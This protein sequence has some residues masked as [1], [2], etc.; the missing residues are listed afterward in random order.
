MVAHGTSQFIGGVISQ[1]WRYT[2]IQGHKFGIAINNEVAVV[3]KTDQEQS[4]GNDAQ[5]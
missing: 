4:K 1:T 5:F 2:V 3:M